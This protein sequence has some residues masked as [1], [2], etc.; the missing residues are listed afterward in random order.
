MREITISIP[1][2]IAIIL[3]WLAGIAFGTL[4]WEWIFSLF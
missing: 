1:T 3:G 4:F 2:I